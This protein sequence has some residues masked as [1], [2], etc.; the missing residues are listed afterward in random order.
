MRTPEPLDP[1]IV[2]ARFNGGAL[3]VENGPLPY[4]PTTEL[5]T[6]RGGATD[7]ALF[8]HEA[9]DLAR[10][11]TL[12]ADHAAAA[13]AAERRRAPSCDSQERVAP[14]RMES[15][16]ANVVGPPDIGTSPGRAT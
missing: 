8:A 13:L 6:V 16:D 15:V 1:I 11:L 14:R 3:I 2:D 7:L 10:A 5:I 9:R 4:E 12:A